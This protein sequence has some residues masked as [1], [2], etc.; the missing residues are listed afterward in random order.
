M[1]KTPDNFQ[2]KMRATKEGKTKTDKRFHQKLS[3]VERK[4][5]L[6]K[7]RQSICMQFNNTRNEITRAQ[8]YINQRKTG[9]DVFD[10]AKNANP[11][12]RNVRKTLWVD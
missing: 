10:G 11:E 12:W 4:D 8:T 7:F 6:L 9:Q 1:P 2:E 5:D 3:E